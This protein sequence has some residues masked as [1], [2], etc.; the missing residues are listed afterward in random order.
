MDHSLFRVNL[1]AIRDILAAHYTN[2][3]VVMMDS[4]DPKY[5]GDFTK[6]AKAVLD[7]IKASEKPKMVLVSAHKEL[8]DKIPSEGV[9]WWRVYP[10]PTDSVKNPL[11]QL[12]DT[13]VV[14]L[15]KVRETILDIHVRPPF[16]SIETCLRH[17]Q[18]CRR[19]VR[20][21]M[22]TPNSGASRKGQEQEN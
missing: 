19:L 15:H 14:A 4:N 16:Q 9:K 1:K 8:R 2:Y 18:V 13:Q 22:L 6:Y 17:S 10:W 12:D 11:V 20:C 3:D 5:S 21:T 7:A